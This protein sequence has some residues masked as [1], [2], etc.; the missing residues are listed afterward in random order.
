MQ[1]KNM[2]DLLKQVTRMRKDMERVSEELKSRYVEA[3]AGGD[4]VRVTF[5]G[6]QELVKLSIDPRAVAPGSDGKVDIEMLED[7][8]TAAVTQG[9]EKSKVLRNEEMDKASG[10][11]GAGLPGFF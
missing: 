10:G 2:G 11:L 4:L 5:N 1:G 3:S 8:I 9:V 7:L 6:Q